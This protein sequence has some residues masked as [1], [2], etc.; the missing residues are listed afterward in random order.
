MYQLANLY[1]T[2]KECVVFVNVFVCASRGLTV[3]NYFKSADVAL[4]VVI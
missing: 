1:P 3:S 2:Q 4:K